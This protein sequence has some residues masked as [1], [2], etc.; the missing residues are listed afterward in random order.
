MLVVDDQAAFREVAG[1]LVEVTPGFR[2][3]GEAAS[4]EE[5][6][7]AV[8]EVRPDLVLLDVRMPGMGGAEAA[9]RIVGEHPQVRVVLMSVAADAETVQHPPAAAFVRK[10]DLRP[11]AL[12]RLWGGRDGAP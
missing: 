10:Q 7:R 12:Q 8:E 9:R 5:A 1:Q 11:E 6:L 4:G 3:C 2:L